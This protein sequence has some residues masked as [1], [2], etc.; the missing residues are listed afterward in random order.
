MVKKSPDISCDHCVPS[1]VPHSGFGTVDLANLDAGSV[2][3]LMPTYP[4]KLLCESRPLSAQHPSHIQRGVDDNLNW[5]WQGVINWVT[6]I[7]MTQLQACHIDLNNFEMKRKPCIYFPY[8]PKKM[9]VW[10][11]WKKNH[12]DGMFHLSQG[13]KDYVAPEYV[14]IMLNTHEKFRGIDKTL[15]M[16]PVCCS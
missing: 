6:Q 14:L 8:Q 5:T 4:I 12:I 15:S 13:R 2:L 11:N 10:G 3:P 9:L 1:R 7:L 16:G